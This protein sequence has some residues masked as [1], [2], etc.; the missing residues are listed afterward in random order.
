[1]EPFANDLTLSYFKGVSCP[2]KLV[3]FLEANDHVDCGCITESC[4]Y[5]ERNMKDVR[6]T[7]II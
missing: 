4:V 3:Y 1:M 5:S 2:F 6:D 7:S